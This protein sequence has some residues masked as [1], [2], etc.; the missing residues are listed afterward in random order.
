MARTLGDFFKHFSRSRGCIADPHGLIVG[1]VEECT[2]PCLALG[3]YGIEFI[4]ADAWHGSSTHA[5]CL[6]HSALVTNRGRSSECLLASTYDQIQYIVSASCH[7]LRGWRYHAGDTFIATRLC[8]SK[9]DREITSLTQAASPLAA[10]KGRS[11]LIE[12]RSGDVVALR[13]IVAPLFLPGL[14]AFHTKRSPWCPSP[15]EATRQQRS[16]SVQNQNNDLM[17]IKPLI[18]TL[19]PLP[20]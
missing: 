9:A 1:H 18:M 12:L 11:T 8:A 16:L 14:L 6:A 15:G 5:S 2:L 13:L 4:Q 7:V 10:N 20:S 19:M 17:C 3:Y